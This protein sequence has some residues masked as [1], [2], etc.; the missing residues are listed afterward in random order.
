MKKPHRGRASLLLIMAAL[1]MVL[2]V[3]VAALSTVIEFVYR[4]L[5]AAPVRWLLA[6]LMHAAR[7]SKT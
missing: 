1:A 3:Y 7:P 4:H 2:L 6:R 5:I